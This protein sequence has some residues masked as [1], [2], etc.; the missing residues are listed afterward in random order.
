MQAPRVLSTHLSIHVA[1]LRRRD[2]GK[3]G[4][5][6]RAPQRG[7]FT[8]CHRLEVA[9]GRRGCAARRSRGTFGSA[10]AEYTIFISKGLDTSTS[11]LASPPP[12]HL[13]PAKK[14]AL[15]QSC[16]HCRGSASLMHLKRGLG[17]ACPKGGCYGLFACSQRAPW[18]T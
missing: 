8:G 4:R 7:H 3:L 10:P 9:S 12:M 11:V 15:M 1:C 16:M 14:Q 5:G 13:L 2:S 18:R 6:E 17:Y